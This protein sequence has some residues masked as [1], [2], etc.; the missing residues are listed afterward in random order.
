MAVEVNASA[1]LVVWAAWGAV[2]LWLVGAVLTLRGIGRQQP[3]TPAAVNHLTGSDAPPVSILVPARD[4]ERRVLEASVRSMLAQDYGNFEV[5]AVND[6]STDATPLILRS[7]ARS[8]ARLRVVEGIE[9]PA[10]WLGKPHAM[11]QAH[12]AAQGVWVLA[13]DADMIFERTALRTAVGHALAG[14]YDAVTLL[15]RVDCLTFWERV[16]MPTFGWFMLIALPLERV[17]NPR[18]REALGVGGFF[19]IRRAAL[20]RVGGYAAVRRDVA[21]DLRMAEILKASGARLRVE[22]APDLARTRMQ[23]NFREIWEGFT[24]NLFAGAKFSL[25]QAVAGATG[26]L[27]VSVA[28]PVVALLSALM[29]AFGGGGG[30]WLQLFIPACLVWLI[31]FVTFGVIN[32]RWEI[33]LP[34]AATVPLGHALFV[35]ILLNSAI[36]IATGRGVTWKGRTLYKRATSNDDR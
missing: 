23:T 15:P 10:G 13:T 2:A 35:V 11:H 17:N 26:V 28:P 14:G 4:E 5:V 27:M 19:L 25:F 33:P 18:R 21:E 7:I 29:L 8:D 36:R 3:L 1:A 34:Y 16:F 31:Q 12:R 22:Y 20:E 30:M 6:R 24:K 9:P 32:T